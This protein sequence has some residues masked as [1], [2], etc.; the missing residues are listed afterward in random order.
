MVQ[1]APARAHALG[2]GL[3]PPAGPRRSD[4]PQSVQAQDAAGAA[5]APGPGPV[6]RA[7]LPRLHRRPGR[8]RD[9]G[10]H[11]VPRAACR[12]GHTHT[13]QVEAVDA[14]GQAT[15]SRVRT[16][17]IDATAPTL[18]SRSSGKRAARA[19]RCGSSSGR[20]RQGLGLKNIRVD[21]GDKRV[22][23]ARR[24]S[25]AATL[26]ARQLQAARDAARQGGQRPARKSGCG[27]SRDP[28]RGPP[29][30]GARWPAAADGHPQRDARLVLG[31]RASSPTSRR[32]RRAPPALVAAGAEIVD[33]GGESARG[34]PP[35]GRGGRGD[36]ARGAAG[37]RI[38]AE[39]DV[40]V[41]VDTY[42][43]AVAEAAVAAGAG[44]VNDV[45]GLRD[46]ALAEVCARTGAAL[47]LMHTRGG[48][49]RGRCS[50]PAP[51]TTWSRTSSGSCR[52]RSRSRARAGWP[53]S[54]SSSTP[55]PD[56]A[57]TP[58]QT[59]AVLRRL[60][61]LRALGRPLLL[62]ASRKDFVGAITGR[63]PAER[64]AGDAGGA[65]RRRRRGRVDP[66]RARRRRGGRL[67]RRAVGA[68]RRARARAPR[69]ASHP[70]A[71]RSASLL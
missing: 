4:R 22:E 67:P 32:A 30:A 41:S 63:A 54:R 48:A 1:G 62:A 9:D 60:D 55:G 64:D 34:G 19:A 45:S 69:R 5:L 52:A 43:P 57:K 17:R 65:R 11:A 24:R 35:A 21:Y 20:R 23:P 18:R 40:L 2:R 71:S 37:R 68:A 51:T 33:V 61:A 42:K 53:R 12:A 6:G 25:A 44:I 15:P 26:P 7:A 70:S 47:V 39:H 10:R 16:L 58:A 36:R 14:R 31:R 49:A 28:A 27:S 38:V 13:W 3:R 46:P 50:I 8:R 29:A 59:V 56:F 66:A